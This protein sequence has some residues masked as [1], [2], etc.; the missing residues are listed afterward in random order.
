MV[1]FDKFL[2]TRADRHIYVME[3]PKF[4]LSY[5][6]MG[7]LISDDMVVFIF[8]TEKTLDSFNDDVCTEVELYYGET[9]FTSS[10]SV[11][12]LDSLK[13]LKLSPGFD[14]DSVT[15]GS[16]TD[17]DASTELDPCSADCIICFM[18]RT[19]YLDS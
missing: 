7:T 19:D 4:A 17:F 9:A 3:M 18:N 16:S 10:N 1:D 2:E 6:K 11:T 15:L 12:V 5:P 14:L 13:N 8:G